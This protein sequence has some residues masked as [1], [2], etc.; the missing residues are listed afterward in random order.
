LFSFKSPN[1]FKIKKRTK[2]EVPVPFITE[3]LLIRGELFH[4]KLTPIGEFPRRTNIGDVLFQNEFVKIVSP[5]NG[6]VYNDGSD[7]VKLRIDGELNYKPIFEKRE[8]SKIDFLSKIDTLGIVSLDFLNTT[9]HDLFNL[10]QNDKNSKIVFSPFTKEGIYDYSDFLLNKFKMEL[11]TLETYLQK[12]FPNSQFNNFFNNKLKLYQYPEGNPNYFIYK[13]LQIPLTNNFPHDN[14]LYLGPETIYHLIKGLYYNTPFFERHLSI[15]MINKYGKRE[16]N[17]KIY[18]VKNGTNLTDFINSFKEKYDY[19][20]FIINSLFEKPIVH[21]IGE[22][23][24]FNIYKHHALILSE[25]KVDYSTTNICIDCND[26]TYFCPVDIDPRSL[27]DD[28]KDLFEKDKCIQCGLCS[29][30]CPAQIDFYTLIE[31]QKKV[32]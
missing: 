31:N 11:D 15:V 29:V 25:Q 9:L 19:K 21:N 8:L 3:S 18:N 6:L 17:T 26:C 14:V 4:H 5:I 32:N 1:I 24:T 10:F 28:N 27:L 13:Y 22:E 16:G 7:Q 23:F 12:I 20:Y 30:Y 2:L